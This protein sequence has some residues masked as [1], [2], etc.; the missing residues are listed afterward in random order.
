MAARRAGRDS[1]RRERKRGEGA[2]A[3]DL[4][5]L[6]EIPPTIP[7]GARP[8]PAGADLDEVPELPGT[9]D[10]EAL[11]E[12]PSGGDITVPAGAGPES[13]PASSAL[14]P[15]GRPALTLPSESPDELAVL[16]TEVAAADD[17][18]VRAE[19]SRAVIET[20][21]AEVE[22]R[23]GA[24]VLSR[25]K[26]SDPPAALVP[27]LEKAKS[28]R[29][30]H[31][32]GRKR[33]EE[34]TAAA[35]TATEALT[36]ARRKA[37]EVSQAR[38][39]AA[40]LAGGTCEM[41]ADHLLGAHRPQ[42]VPLA[43]R[44]LPDALRAY[45][46]SVARHAALESQME[47]AA[48]PRRA[49]FARERDEV[50]RRAKAIAI[51]AGA[52]L[53]PLVDALMKSCTACASSRTTLV[54]AAGKLAAA[55]RD[56]AALGVAD[57]ESRAASAAHEAAATEAREREAGRAFDE[58]APR[59]GR[60][61][62]GARAAKS[63]PPEPESLDEQSWRDLHARSEK[64]E[65]YRQALAL[66]L[67]AQQAETAAKAATRV[68]EAARTAR[69]ALEGFSAAR[70]QIEEEQ[71]RGRRE[72]E[73]STRTAVEALEAK[74]R[75][76]EEAAKRRVAEG[77]KSAAEALEKLRGVVAEVEGKVK[78]LETVG[79]RA[80]AIEKRVTDL[81][82]TVEA[83]R[84]KAADVESLERRGREAVSAIESV[85]AKVEWISNEAADGAKRITALSE[86]VAQLTGEVERAVREA[87][88]AAQAETE[89]LAK[90]VD[91]A[92]EALANNEAKIRQ[93]RVQQTEE[94]LT[95]VKTRAAQIL[96]ELQEWVRGEAGKA[97]AGR[98]APPA[99]EA[100]EGE[101]GAEAPAAEEPEDPRAAAR[102]R[103]RR[104]RGG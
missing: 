35:K 80:E 31:E 100:P 76:A 75:E 5:D 8:A 104:K 82:A 13:R 78:A 64:L 56:L 6:P 90:E 93:Q 36:E 88:S 103:L 59:A 30:A 18:F 79:G 54:D 101:E 14:R 91:A 52:G 66:H 63:S 15:A 72:A 69:E 57:L 20:A 23:V 10:L 37:A 9:P 38:Q 92:R 84:S 24:A 49:E 102:E 55:D 94:L 89:K 53:L 21:M 34:A 42:I 7:P 95:T 27:V 70:R 19:G 62:L 47:A 46:E 99:E 97:K 33:I 48:G 40:M 29:E 12:L 41:L 96:K 50:G 87:S 28:L 77:E 17:R 86:R 65:Q 4:E 16:P 73:A 1:A 32:A 83:A 98:A 85:G 3:E 11:P 58:L 68:E 25:E 39:Q 51:A 45:V 43:A 74:A 22:A 67:G 71:A 26:V 60:I 2:P 81:S 44:P 61:W